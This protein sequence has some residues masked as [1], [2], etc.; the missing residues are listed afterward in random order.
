MNGPTTPPTFADKLFN[1]LYNARTKHN[2]CLNKETWLSIVTSFVEIERPNA[3]KPKS[4]RISQLT[5]EA[6]ID[7][8]IADPIFTGI[9]VRREYGKCV[10]WC[11]TNKKPCTR[12]RFTNWLNKADRTMTNAG[13][14]A[15]ERKA[16]IEEQ[17]QAPPL[18]WPDFM[19]TKMKAWKADN[20]PEY[21]PPGMS[22]LQNGNF[23]GMPKSWRD[24]CWKL[25]EQKPDQPNLL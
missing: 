21:D 3:P 15:A 17:T 10:F 19:E 5:D 11:K 12:R 8:L 2:G 14:G 13:A 4:V 25:S 7:S 6:W 23:F 9:D 16:I 22:A 1:V 24:E 20:G 18:Q